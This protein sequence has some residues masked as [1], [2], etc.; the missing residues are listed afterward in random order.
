MRNKEIEDLELAISKVIKYG[1]LAS[2]AIMLIGLIIFLVTGSSG[3]PGS[4]YPTSLVEIFQGLIAFKP[5]AMMMFGLFLLI[6]TPVLRVGVSILLF[7]KEKDY[8]FVRI[9]TLVFIILIISFLLGK[10]K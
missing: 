3:Y 10:A 2:A 1:V 5:Y 4:Y 6:L 9:T 7:L 8:T